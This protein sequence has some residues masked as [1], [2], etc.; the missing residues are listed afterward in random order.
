MDGLTEIPGVPGY[1]VDVNG[2]VYSTKRGRW[3]YKIAVRKLKAWTDDRGYSHVTLRPYGQKKRHSVSRLVAMAFHGD[4]PKNSVVA[5]LDGNPKNN[6]PSNLGYVSQ[7]E[8]IGH[9]W[10]H[11][12]MI[13]G[14]TS[15]L[16]TM[17]DETVIQIWKQI[18]S[19]ASCREIRHQ[20]NVSTA[21]YYALKKGRIRKHITGINLQTL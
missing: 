12:T 13:F 6:K 1:Y 2:F 7:C 8:N 9:K 11:G 4:P 10:Q 18:C 15:H 19:G 20:F 14:E 3:G 5:H 21:Y 17:S 16:S